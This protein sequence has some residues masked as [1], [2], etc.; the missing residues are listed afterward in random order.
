MT[1]TSRSRRWI[2]FSLRSLLLLMTVVAAYVAGWVSN[3]W[4]HNR[5]IPAPQVVSTPF[6]V[7]SL[8]RVDPTMD[9]RQLIEQGMKADEL[10]MQMRSRALLRDS[11]SGLRP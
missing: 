4:R 1:D 8:R 5:V 7:I 3:E 6:N 10:E 2:Q 11:R 9:R